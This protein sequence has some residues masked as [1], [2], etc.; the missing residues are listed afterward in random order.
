MGNG[1]Q[2][3]DLWLPEVQIMSLILGY[4]INETTG[5][6]NEEHVG[7]RSEALGPILSRVVHNFI[8]TNLNF[9]PL[10]INCKQFPRIID[11]TGPKSFIRLISEVFQ[12]RAAT[13]LKWKAHQHLN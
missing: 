5:L 1:S 4:V 3:S 12:E 13:V 6:N 2:R 10:S 7:T 11:Q 9:P 8:K